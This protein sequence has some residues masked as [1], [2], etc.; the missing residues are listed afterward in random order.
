MAATKQP[1]T[2]TV[3]E[4]KARYTPERLEKLLTGQITGR[5]L[6][7]LTG[8]QMLKMAVDGFTQYEQGRYQEAQQ[9][10]EILVF[11]EPKESYYSIALGAVYMAQ[12]ELEKAEGALTNAIALNTTEVAAFV[13]RGEVYLRTGRIAEA[14]ADFKKAVGLDPKGKDPLTQRA[15]MLA[16]AVLAMIK[17]AQ[18]EK[19]NKGGAAKGP[20]P[21][22]KPAAAKPATTTPVAKKK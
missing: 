5:E 9:I 3:E 20:A 8:P 21:A 2:L 22:S 18:A 7:Q 17:K 1:T 10:F 6:H 12:E 19:A 14:A 15:R 13:N 11:L 4:F 16:G